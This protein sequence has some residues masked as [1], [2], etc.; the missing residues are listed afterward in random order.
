[1][2]GE[3][4]EKTATETVTQPLSME[5]RVA[6]LEAQNEGLKRVGL[7]GLVLILLLGAIVVHQTYSDLRSI[8]THDIAVLNS[9]D[10]LAGVVTSDTQGR[11]QFLSAR[12]GTLPPGTDNLP[13]D[14]QGY[15]FYDS[16]G[17]PRMLLGE[18]KD[19]ATVFQVLDPTRGVAFEPLDPALSGP[20]PAPNGAAAKP[21]A[22]PTPKP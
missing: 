16:D 4:S 19:K 15:V 9:K 7:L 13:A 6:Y 17:H 14:F 20:P 5:E 11:I 8:T 2:Q 18:N 3:E 21:P 12:Y 1:M 22:S 10:A